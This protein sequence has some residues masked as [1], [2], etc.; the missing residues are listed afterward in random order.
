MRFMLNGQPFDFDGD[1]D[2]PLLWV[3]RDA[4]GLTGTKYGCGIGA[5]G[6]CTVHL[7][8]EAARSCVLPVG[9]VAGRSVTTIEGLSH[10]R[11]HPVQRAWI[12]KDVPQCGY[13]QSGMVMAAAALLARHRKPTDAQIDAAVTNLCRCATYQRIREAIHVAAG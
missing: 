5:C 1:P 3:V 6:A 11:S 2:T 8:G 4:A 12:E 7:D 13:C 10:D 9:G